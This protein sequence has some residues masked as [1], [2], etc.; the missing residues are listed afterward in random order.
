MYL[1]VRRARLSG[2]G[3]F[4]WATTIGHRVAEVIGQEVQ[5]WATTLSPGFSTVSWTSRWDDLGAMEKG[6]G[7][8]SGDSEYLALVDKGR[9]LI[10]GGVDDGLSQFVYEGAGDV[11]A[12]KYVGSVVSVCAPGQIVTAMTNGVAIAQKAESIAGRP[13]SFLSGVTGVYGGVGWITGYEDLAAFEQAQSKL[14]ADPSWLPFID[15]VSGCFHSDAGATQ[16]TLHM[17]IG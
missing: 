15:S 13:T 12:V 10:T 5:T 17:K 4:E 11:G 6:F 8:L 9:S 1:L 14:A 16:S 3:G 2:S 7:K